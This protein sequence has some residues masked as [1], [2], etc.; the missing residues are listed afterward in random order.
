MKN[1]DI[2]TEA[3]KQN[4]RLQLSYDGHKRTVEVHAIG[5]SKAGKTIVRV[6]QTEGDSQSKQPVGWKLLN[7]HEATALV[8]VDDASEAPRTG[9]KR[10]DRAMA[11]IIVEL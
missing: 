7:L 6:W 11:E 5:T 8:I 1:I 2:P 3:L 10:A 4:K 9:Y